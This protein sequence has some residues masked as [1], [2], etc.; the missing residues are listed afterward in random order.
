MA[1]YSIDPLTDPR[2]DGLLIRHRR[3]NVFHSRGWLSA[4]RQSYG[5]TPV[6]FTT[7]APASPLEKALVFCEVKS[8][9]T[10][11]RL[12]SLPFSDH[13]DPLANSATEVAE[14]LFHLRE[15]LANTHLKFAEFRPCA[16]DT[17]EECAAAD[18][19]SSERFLLH[20]LSL[21]SPVE[22]LYRGLHKDCIRRKLHRAEREH[23][24][25]QSG[26]SEPLLRTFYQLQVQTR[27]RQGLPPQPLKWFRNL[28]ASMGD[29]LTIR[30]A[31][32]DDR[33]VAAI[34][35][36]SFKQTMTYKYG[37][38]N[39]RFNNLGGAPFLFWKTIQEAKEGGMSQLDLG[40]SE[41]D[42][43][44]LV[45]FKDRLGARRMDLKYYRLV[46]SKALSAWRMA[47]A[48][49]MVPNPRTM[50]L[51]RSLA[52]HIPDAVLIA[53]GKLLYRHIG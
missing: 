20:T 43:A 25:Y 23:L 53:A 48:P 3:A 11:R 22:L 27:R 13:C 12:V 16:G 36:L 21:E 32:K 9:I 5:Y 35:T 4:L 24:A 34:L 6:A 31:S 51:P 28:M 2:W 1:V 37:C 14:L 7:S 45:K 44:G 49:K 39:E 10:G 17:M 15:H 40:R 26:R 52:R 41:P 38:S 50:Q 33:P 19:Q 42:N 47:T 30:V 8:W 18:L 46:P 29:Q